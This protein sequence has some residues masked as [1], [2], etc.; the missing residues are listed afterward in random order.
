MEKQYKLPKEFGKKW[1]KALRSGD[2]KQA[3]KTLYDPT[4]DG[5]CCLGLACKLEYPLYYLKSSS[6]GYAGII[7]KG[8][9][10]DELKYNLK[11]I[12]KELLGLSGGSPLVRTLVN[13]NDKGESFVK[14]AN[15][16]EKN[17]EL[18]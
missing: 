6:G 11:K 15:W 5:Y 1:L 18:Y 14:I 13:K 12:P 16:I 7:S 9:Q 4:T 3:T 2:Y 17:V 10:P 8:K